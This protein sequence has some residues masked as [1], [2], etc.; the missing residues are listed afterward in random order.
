MDAKLQK[1]RETLAAGDT[2]KA[3]KMLR[4]VL[5]NEPSADA[6]VLAAELTEGTEQKI[7]LVRQALAMNALHTAANRLLHQLE[8]SVPKTTA[9]NEWQRKVG[10]KPVDEIQRRGKKDRFQLQAERQRAWTRLGCVSMIIFSVCF[11][12]AMYRAI[13]LMP[14]FLNAKIATVLGRPTPVAEIEGV[15]L[16]DA[17]GA[18]FIMSP[19]LQEKA[20][21]QDMEILDSGYMHE[22][23]FEGKAG[24]EYVIYIQFLSVNAS[25]VPRNVV[26]ADPDER[27]ATKDCIAGN[28]LKGG[29]NVTLSCVLTKSGTYRVRIIGREG[30]SIGAYF[31]G[32]QKL[33]FE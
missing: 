28:I 11:S 33:D 21:T 3:R 18:A 13:G 1:I 15:P 10:E 5:K 7:A 25:N 12:F 31:I 6:W 8:G 32:V 30:E 19:S 17:P 4:W 26:V 14:S 24:E 29:S 16:V 2:D 27:N 23:F 9:T 20:T 22:H